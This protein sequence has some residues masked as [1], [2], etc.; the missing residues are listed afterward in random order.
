MKS[1]AATTH[2]DGQE[3]LK[4]MKKEKE[5]CSSHWDVH[6]QLLVMLAYSLSFIALQ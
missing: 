1:Y 6:G 3:R 4:N 5:G 2:K